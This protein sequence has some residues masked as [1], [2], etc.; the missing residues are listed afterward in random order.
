M[1][2]EEFSH[3]TELL[4]T[5]FTEK[6]CNEIFGQQGPRLWSKHWMFESKKSFIIFNKTFN[7]FAGG[8]YIYL[9]SNLDDWIKKIVETSLVPYGYRLVKEE[10]VNFS[11][12]AIDLAIEEAKI[13]KDMENASIR[14]QEK[15]KAQEEAKIKLEEAKKIKLQEK[16][17]LQ[18]NLAQ[19][20]AREAI[21]IAQEAIKIAQETQETTKEKEEEE[22]VN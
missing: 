18:I 4:N 20:K 16:I 6:T 22:E 7:S 3:L 2:I 19:E 17:T 5:L 8:K 11:K 14:E 10:G 21:K 1:N 12:E 13:I 9:R 15:I